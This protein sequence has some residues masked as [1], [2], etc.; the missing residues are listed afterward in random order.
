MDQVDL[1]IKELSLD[2]V[3]AAA[4]MPVDHCQRVVLLM[5]GAVGD[6]ELL[7]PPHLHLPAQSSVLHNSGL[8]IQ[9]SGYSCPSLV[10][11]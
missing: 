8:R 7:V 9:G 5:E 1:A 4:P 2:A 11:H 10:V 6:V 3:L